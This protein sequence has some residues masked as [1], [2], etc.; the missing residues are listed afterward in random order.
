MA[1]GQT[2]DHFGAEEYVFFAIMII[3]TVILLG[4]TIWR[5]VVELKE[6]YFDLFRLSQYAFL[7]AYL[8]AWMVFYVSYL[9]HSTPYLY[10]IGVW[11]GSATNMG[12]IIIN[13]MLWVLIIV[14][15][16]N[17]MH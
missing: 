13:L 16:S 11:I 17:I 6:D 3:P 10:E 2:N 12:Y 14:H 4:N 5:T 9:F 8:I 7:L 1:E 15:I